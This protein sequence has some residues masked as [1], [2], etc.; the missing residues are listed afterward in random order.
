MP[1]SGADTPR[2][3]HADTMPCGDVS[4][5]RHGNADNRTSHD[6]AGFCHH[7]GIRGSDRDAD[8]LK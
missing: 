4:I 3:Q 8:A 6:S 1:H 5:A 7:A 2:N